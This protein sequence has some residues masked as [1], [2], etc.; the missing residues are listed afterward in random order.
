MFQI[1]YY[2]DIQLIFINF[3]FP[4]FAAFVKLK[5]CS[6]W[7]TRMNRKWLLL[8]KKISV[9]PNKSVWLLSW[10]FWGTTWRISS[11]TSMIGWN[12]KEWVFGFFFLVDFYSFSFFLAR[13]NFCQ[14]FGWCCHLSRSLWCR[15][16]YGC[17]EL[18]HS[19]VVGPS[20]CRYRCWKLRCPQTKRGCWKLRKVDGGSNPKVFG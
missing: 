1:L 19:I 15:L 11:T 8:S 5:P 18:S 7:S 9:V 6:K 10:T 16:G 12:Q 4:L 2:R 17:L 13:E 20:C 3:H 14:P